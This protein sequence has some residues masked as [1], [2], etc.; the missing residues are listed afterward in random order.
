MMRWGHILLEKYLEAIECLQAA[1]EICIN[2]N[3]YYLA[4]TSLQNIA[5][6][7]LKIERRDLALQFSDRALSIATELG[8]PLAKECQEFKDNIN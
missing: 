2:T 8:I 1:I 5:A 3:N 4:A 6:I 7:C